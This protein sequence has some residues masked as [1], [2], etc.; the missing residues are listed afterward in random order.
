MQAQVQQTVCPKPTQHV[1][2]GGRWL[3][4]VQGGDNSDS[5]IGTFFEVLNAI[6]AS[7]SNSLSHLVNACTMHRGVVALSQGAIAK[8][9]TTDEIDAKIQENIREAGYGGASK[10]IKQ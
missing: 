2:L 1:C 10:I 6:A 4:W 3:H 5:A 7:S 8:G 9:Y